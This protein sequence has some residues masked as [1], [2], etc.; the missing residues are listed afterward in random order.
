MQLRLD[1]IDPHDRELIG[2]WLGEISLHEFNMN[3]LVKFLIIQ[4]SYH[5]EQGDGFYKLCEQIYGD[6]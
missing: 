5:R 3:G 2:E 1:F 6:D 4:K